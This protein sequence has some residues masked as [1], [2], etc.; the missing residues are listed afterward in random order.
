MADASSAKPAWLEELDETL[1]STS[2][3]YEFPRAI[4]GLIKEYL[5]CDDEN[6]SAT[7]AQRVDDLYDGIYLPKFDGYRHKKKGWTSFLIVFYDILFG[8]GLR[9][10]YDDAR[11]DKVIQLLCELRKLPA[12]S[13]KIFVV[14]TRR[15]LHLI[16]HSFLSKFQRLTVPCGSKPSN[17]SSAG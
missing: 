2:P 10:P 3:A 4:A 5:H 16:S 1:Q 15:P 9:I 11:Q 7:F 17:P 14:S 8:V 12:R 13:V 6:A